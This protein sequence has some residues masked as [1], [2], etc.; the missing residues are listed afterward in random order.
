MK[1]RWDT[2][3]TSLKKGGT[4]APLLDVLT[5]HNLYDTV[6][7]GIAQ[8]RF[9]LFHI[10]MKIL[11]LEDDKPLLNL[12]VL[13]L[14]RSGH[15]VDFAETAT[16]AGELL[17]QKNFDLV[18]SDRQLSDDNGELKT[19]LLSKV[20]HPTTPVIVMSGEYDDEIVADVMSKGASQFLPKPFRLP[21]L[22]NLIARFTKTE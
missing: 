9:A 13:I 17:R 7:S 18:I 8:Y 20:L 19:L 10:K 12:L 2:V 22:L 3:G 5:F 15:V 16:V 21:E 6:Q 4:R 11:I 14:T 1:L